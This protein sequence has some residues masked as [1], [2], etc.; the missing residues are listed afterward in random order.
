MLSIPAAASTPAAAPPLSPTP[1]AKSAQTEAAAESLAADTDANV[2]IISLRDE[3][4]ETFA[5]PEGKREVVQHLRPV[6]ARVGGAWKAI[7]N[8]LEIRPDGSVGPKVAAVGM[9]FSHGGTS[10]PL[11]ELDRVGRKMA[12]S[13]PKPLPVPTLN[14]DTATY[15]SVLPGVD[16]T[17][18]ADID[19]YH[20]LLVVHTPEAAANPE[21]AEITF[22]LNAPGLDVHETPDGRLE[23]LDKSAGGVVFTSLKPI[24][25]DSAGVPDTVSA[26]STTTVSDGPGELSRVAPIG[27]E[28]ASA[29]KELRLTPDQRLLKDEQTQWPVMIDPQSYTPKAGDWTMVSKYW[30]DSPQYR[31]NGDSNQ[32]VGYCG[33]SYCA[34]YDTKRLFYKFP[35]ARFDGKTIISAEFV[36]HETWSASCDGRTVELWRTKGM[37]AT[38]TWDN[39]ADD[40]LDYL[41]YRDVAYGGDGCAG[42]A[43]VEFNAIDGVKYAAA[44]GDSYTT[45]GLK[46]KDEGDRYAWK[47]FTDD[48]YLRVTYNV[49]PRQPSMSQLAMSPG[50]DCDSVANKDWVRSRPY[51][52]ANN[53]TDPDKDRVKVQFGVFWDT[54]DGNGTSMRW[55]VITGYKAAGSD[56]GV[57]LPTMIPAN[58]LVSWSVRVSDGAAWSPWVS[59]GNATNCYFQYDTSVPSGPKIAS[60]DY[61]GSMTGDPGDKWYDGV[62]RHGTFT[63][64]SSSSD[65]VKY[66]WGINS[67]PVCDSAHTITT[68]GGAEKSVSIAAPKPGLN[69]ITAVAKDIAGNVSPTDEQTT[70]MFRVTSGQPARAQW[71]FDERAGATQSVGTAGERTLAIHG[72][73]ALG[74][75]GAV[76]SSIAFDGVDD[77]LESD[78]ATVDT[79]L[80]FSVSAWVNMSTLPSEAAIIAA[81]PGNNSPGFELYYSSGYQRWAFNQYTA[82]TANATPVRAMQS[83]AGGVKTGEWVHLVGL[84][85]SVDDVLQLYVNGTLA[86]STPYTTPWDARRGLRIGAGSYSGVADSFFPGSV[87]EVRLFDKGLAQSEITALYNKQP[88]GNGRPAR[89][90]F[91]LDETPTDADGAP[92]TEVSGKA[93]AFPAVYQGGVV[94]GE[95]TPDGNAATFDGVNDYATT[96][97]PYVHTMR[98]FTVSAWVK[99]SKKPTASAIVA[100]QPGDQKSAFELYYS[101]TYGWSF[102]NYDTDSTTSGIT[103]ATVNNPNA[104]AP[105]EWTL[106]TGVYSQPAGQLRLY[107]NGKYV[108]YVDHVNTWHGGKPMVIGAG[109]YGGVAA[110]FFPGQIDDVQVFDRMLPSGEISTMYDARALVEGRWKL[111]TAS[112]SPAVSPDDVT[113]QQGQHPLT[114]GS[115]AQVDPSAD[116]FGQGGGLLLDGVTGYASTSTSPV[117]TNT[118]FTVAARVFALGRPQKPVTVLSQVGSN[119]NGFKVRYVPDAPP[120][121]ST[122]GQSVSGHWELRV[123]DADST[124]AGTVVATHT[125]FQNGTSWNHIAVV[126]DAMGDAFGGQIRLYVDKELVQNVCADDDG[127]GKPNEAGCVTRVSWSSS[128]APFDATKGL[129]LGRAKTG[130]S[131]WGEYWPG[132]IDDVWAFQGVLSDTQIQALASETE[133]LTAK[134]P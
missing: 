22:G 70:Y 92:R 123:Y 57:Q 127:D 98:S 62:G 87:D 52:T 49:P 130:A 4:S 18:R 68:S 119:T 86:G 81:Q 104:I 58:K 75:T 40:W 9:R 60:G 59:D 133:L 64:D 122:D 29:A 23:A 85:N 15:E 25:W 66:C 71:S 106:L 65:V 55:N 132:A 46:A 131:S 114:L 109:S 76:G 134:G 17:L 117:H 32:G 35:T 96:G 1:A 50:G 19:G 20:E 45:F 102:N 120:P 74:G 91:K 113:V 99:L 126:Y 116:F 129:Q 84:Y 83:A 36:A 3:S 41:S 8:T 7:D 103:R 94:A 5:T 69:F 30:H 16:L 100:A 111:N 54:G 48:A 13:W 47:R 107:V 124:T 110:S 37:G 31:F 12:I 63:F 112:G 6:R 93:D 77:Y 80:S 108:D 97:A 78:L 56:F 2:E 14:G 51:V 21:L 43:D 115:G 33:W 10:A 82:D 125:N 53:I 61:P 38:T 101:T 121:E 28:V 88:M 26:R 72:N 128:A 67:D 89:A 44:R 24:M 73:P 105:G 90:V 34:P 11:V 95:D 27:L 39:S 118:S 79:S 42:P